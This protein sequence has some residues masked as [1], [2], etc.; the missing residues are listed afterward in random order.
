M[1][2][3]C[4]IEGAF[5]VVPERQKDTRGYFARTFCR[6]ELASRGLVTSVE[7]CSVSWNQ[8]AGTLRGMHYQVAPR[9]ETKLVRCTRGAIY[10]VLLDLRPTS[11]SFRLWHASELS[12]D[13]GL[14]LYVPEG[15]AH[16]FQTLVDDT[17]VHYQ[18][19]AAYDP[20]CARGVRWDDPAFAI[21]WPKCATRT[22]SERDQKFPL[23]GPELPDTGAES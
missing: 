18:I 9:A 11:S 21:E 6:A 13:N 3:S 1:F 17:E 7:Q 4:Q 23:F 2:R 10:D 19:S 5:V 14:S 12:A 8:R 16:G 15:V 22:I 20:A